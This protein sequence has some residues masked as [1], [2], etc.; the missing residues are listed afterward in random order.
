MKTIGNLEI[1]DRFIDWYKSLDMEESLE[2]FV[3]HVMKA[4]KGGYDFYLIRR[5]KP[6]YFGVLDLFSIKGNK[7]PVFLRV[8]DGTRLAL[9][10]TEKLY[11]RNGQEPLQ[12]RTY[13]FNPILRK[14]FD[15]EDFKKIDLNKIETAISSGSIYDENTGASSLQGYLLKFIEPRPIADASSKKAKEMFGG[16]MD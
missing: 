5:K 7:T 2:D 6:R 12:G 1:T 4:M 9:S 14:H 13:F 16:L 11:L 3:E 15:L 10:S 8:L